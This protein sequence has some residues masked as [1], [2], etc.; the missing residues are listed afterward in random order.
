M[1]AIQ[2]MFLYM[3]QK[4]MEIHSSRLPSLAWG[5]DTWITID[6]HKTNIMEANAAK[7][8]TLSKGRRKKVRKQNHD[9]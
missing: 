7:A 8:G 3:H 2:K 1:Y 4:S 6:R 5:R 9:K